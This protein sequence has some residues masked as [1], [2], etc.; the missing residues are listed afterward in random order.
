MIMHQSRDA[1]KADSDI[2]LTADSDGPDVGSII[3]WIIFIIFCIIIDFPL[4]AAVAW[5]LCDS[6]R[7]QV[8]GARKQVREHV[9]GAREQAT[10]A[11]ERSVG[12]SEGASV[13]SEGAS[14]GA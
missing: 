10:G 5:I 2:L 9:R 14:G 1:G 11:S 7:E 3:F 12:A 6:V 8:R 4:V 13:R